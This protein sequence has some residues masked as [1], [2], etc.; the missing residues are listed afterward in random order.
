MKDIV[1]RERLGS[2]SRHDPVTPEV[3]D[4]L[5]QK[6]LSYADFCHVLERYELNAGKVVHDPTRVLV[7][8]F[9]ADYDKG[10][11]GCLS[12][13]SVPFEEANR[14]MLRRLRRLNQQGNS[15]LQNKDWETYYGTSSELFLD[16]FAPPETVPLPMIIYDFGRRM[17]DFPRK[18]VFGIWSKIYKRIDYSNGMWTSEILDYVFKV[19]PKTAIPD[20]GENGLVTVYRG[21]GEL[22]MPPEK[23]ISWSIHPGNALWFANHSGRGTG[24]V[25]ADAA[26]E[27]IVLWQPGFHYENE[28][29]V[30]PGRIQNIRNMD[31][32]PANEDIFVQLA[33]P[34]LPEFCRFGKQAEKFGYEE[35]SI[36]ED[37]GIKHILR[38]LLL[39]LI[40][41]HNSGAALSIA[42]RDILVYFSLLHDVGRV[43]EE[44]DDGHGRLTR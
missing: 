23:A 20:T 24:V 17:R 34:A 3:V 11:Y 37:H 35:E 22:S 43:D 6:S 19:A 30:W 28:V 32:L 7:N 36:L 42:D 10:M 5:S 12:I 44:T 40:Y 16:F 31:M 15:A 39:S 27:D 14:D 21:V 38:V 41:F 9:Y 8:T 13:S 4:N 33:A 1:V 25:V 2:M 26:P 29:I 18:E